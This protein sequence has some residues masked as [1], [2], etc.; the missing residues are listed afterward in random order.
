LTLLALKEHDWREGDLSI[1]EGRRYQYKGIKREVA[2][3]GSF[4]AYEFILEGLF[5]LQV[6][7]D[8]GRIEI[9]ILM[10]TAQRSENSKLGSSLDL[11]KAEV[12]I[13]GLKTF[14][15]WRYEHAVIYFLNLLQTPSI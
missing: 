6:G 9:G 14:L 8:K 5:R 11:A 2:I 13:G 7:F 4:S 3:E 15:K 12:V 10:L 1:L